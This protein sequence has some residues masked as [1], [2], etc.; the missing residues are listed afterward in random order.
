MLV[1]RP[2]GG[3]KGSGREDVCVQ[4][5]SIDV[6]EIIIHEVGM[7]DVALASRRGGAIERNDLCGL[8]T[9]C[10]QDVRFTILAVLCL[11]AL[12]LNLTSLCFCNRP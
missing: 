8:L 7:I 2:T 3:D 1:P 12:L 4:K 9:D 5:P 10:L 11:F 6:E